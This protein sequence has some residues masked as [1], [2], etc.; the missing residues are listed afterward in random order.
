[1]GVPVGQGLDLAT[2]TILQAWLTQPPSPPQCWPDHSQRL[3]DLCFDTSGQLQ[4]K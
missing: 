4:E 1:M 3:V 2:G